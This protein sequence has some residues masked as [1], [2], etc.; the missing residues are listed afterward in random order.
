MQNN[1]LLDAYIN[2]NTLFIK[3]KNDISFATDGML[4][5]NLKD[6]D[7]NTSDNKCYD[8]I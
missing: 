8:M 1:N 3:Y 7:Y 5:I 4:I 2:N 6:S